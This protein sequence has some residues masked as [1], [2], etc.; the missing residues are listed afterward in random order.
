MIRRLQ[1]C[2][3]ADPF[4]SGGVIQLQQGIEMMTKL[5]V[6]EVVHILGGGLVQPVGTQQDLTGGMPAVCCCVGGNSPGQG[7]GAD[8]RYGRQWVPLALAQRIQ[9]GLQRDLLIRGVP[10]GINGLQQRGLGSA[11]A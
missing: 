9:Q 8:H 10:G 7:A 4:V 6:E 2:R 1:S 3:K 5:V 11:L